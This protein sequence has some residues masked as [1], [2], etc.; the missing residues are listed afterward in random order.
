MGGPSKSRTQLVPQIRAV[1]GSRAR[2]VEAPPPLGGG[3]DGAVSRAG[4]DGGAMR[5]W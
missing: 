2:G 1:F 3:E 4:K 5:P